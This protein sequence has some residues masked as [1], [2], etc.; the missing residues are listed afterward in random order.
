MKIAERKQF[1]SP[2]REIEP[3]HSAGKAG[4]LAT[5]LPKITDFWTINNF[6]I[7]RKSKDSRKK[8]IRFSS[9][10]NRTPVSCVTGGDTRHCTTLNNRF[11]N[12]K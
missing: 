3:R 7:Y 11:L 5:I 12:E 2:R 6:L 8:G 9:A 1:R 4:I 10:G